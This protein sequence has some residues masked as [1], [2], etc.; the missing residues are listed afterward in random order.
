LTLFIGFLSLWGV[1][2]IADSPM[3]SSLVAQNAPSALKG[4]AL[5]TV[6][7]IGFGITIVSIQLLSNLSDIA[8]NFA[9]YTTLGFGPVLGLVALKKW[10]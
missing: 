4:T 1:V 9:L 2:V 8:P 3:F 10:A 5:T 7:G 6:N